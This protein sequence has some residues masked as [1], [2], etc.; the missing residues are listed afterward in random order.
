MISIDDVNPLDTNED[1]AISTNFSKNDPKF[2]EALKNKTT[3][4]IIKNIEKTN[5]K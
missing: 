3:E 5:I 4:Y 1:V 2:S